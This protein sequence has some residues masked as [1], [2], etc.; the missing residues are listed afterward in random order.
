MRIGLVGLAGSL[1]AAVTI[2]SAFQKED[3]AIPLQCAL[4]TQSVEG[5]FEQAMERYCQVID[6]YGAPAYV[7]GTRVGA[8]AKGSHEFDALDL[9]LLRDIEFACKLVLLAVAFFA[10]FAGTVL[11]LLA[12]DWACVLR[13]FGHI[14][15]LPS[16][17]RLSLQGRRFRLS[18]R[19]KCSPETN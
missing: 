5:T 3:P 2:G 12:T 8:P 4:D 15:V 7:G 9:S 11:I 6:R 17:R 1:L 13:G 18:N 19:P 10:A 16:R 14:P